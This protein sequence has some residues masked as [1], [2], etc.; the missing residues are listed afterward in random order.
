MSLYFIIEFFTQFKSNFSHVCQAYNQL[1]AFIS[2]HG[3][4]YIIFNLNKFISHIIYYA[5]K[6]FCSFFYKCLKIIE[7]VL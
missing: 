3:R 4:D 1:I 7:R 5:L 6:I 2:I